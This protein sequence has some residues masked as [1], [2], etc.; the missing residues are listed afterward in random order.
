MLGS[1]NLQSKKI[2]LAYSGGKDSRVL[3]QAIVRLGFVDQLRVVHVNHGLS[4]FASEWERHCRTTCEGLGVEFSAHPVTVENTGKGLEAAARQARYDIFE[5]IVSHN[6]V[7]LT[8]HHAND[9]VETF[10]YRLQRGAGL[11]GLSGIANQ[12]QLAEG[13]LVRPM[14]FCTREDIDVYATQNKLEWINDES[15]EDLRFDRN[16]LRKRVMPVLAE[17][18]PDMC[19]RWTKSIARL[20]T[21]SQLMSEYARDDL[22]CCELREERLGQ[23]IALENFTC[24]TAARQFHVVRE[25]IASCNFTLPDER[26]LQELPRLLN[27]KADANPQLRWGHCE[28]HRFNKRLYLIPNLPNISDSTI[29]WDLSS[30]LQLPDGSILRAEK[31]LNALHEF[32]VT[33]RKG[34]ERCKPVGR[35]HSQSLKKL[36]QEAKLEPW[37]RDRIPLIYRDDQLLMVADLWMCVVDELDCPLPTMHW[38]YLGSGAHIE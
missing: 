34:G 20:Q 29:G 4:S 11:R 35:L 5:N 37:L 22:Q 7:L 32:T 3:L 38:S 14:L 36:L 15:N 12:R 17:R 1:L 10:L 30:P 28:L 9:Q 23:S 6:E 31:E 18:W 21:D 33:F 26:C 25:W 27:A 16:F 24:Y 19:A 13:T 2:I 8:A